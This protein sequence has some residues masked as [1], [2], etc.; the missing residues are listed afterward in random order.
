MKYYVL[1]RNVDHS[2]TG[3]VAHVFELDN[4]GA[5]L[6]WDGNNTVG[7]QSVVIY[8]STEDLIKVH[9]HSGDSLL[10]EQ[11]IATADLIDIFRIVD[12]AQEIYTCI[13]NELFDLEEDSEEDAD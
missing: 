4:F 13:A 7:V 10:L 5:M 2:G 8:K 6:V 9:G 11:D 1:Q 12:D 3:V